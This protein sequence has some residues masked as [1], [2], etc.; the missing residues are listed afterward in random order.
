MAQAKKSTPAKKSAT[1]KKIT[2][3][4]KIWGALSYCWILSLVVL[5]ARKN[6]DYI[7][8]HANQGFL[9]FIV[10]LFWWFPIIGWAAGIAI[11]IAA[12]AGIVKSLQGEKWKLPLVGDLAAKAGEWFVKTVKL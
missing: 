10:S 8:F 5:A 7:R 9:L 1:T 3:D 4:E 6:N 11:V 12:V 2:Q